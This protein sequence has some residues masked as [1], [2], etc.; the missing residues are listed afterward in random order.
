M[1]KYLMAFVCFLAAL[2]GGRYGAETGNRLIMILLS[3][4][5]IMGLVALLIIYGKKDD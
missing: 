1:N 5:G 2:V 4:P 3:L